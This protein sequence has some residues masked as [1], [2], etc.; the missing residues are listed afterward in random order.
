MALVLVFTTLALAF[1]HPHP[2]ASPNGVDIDD[3]EKPMHTT[4]L[5][6]GAAWELSQRAATRTQP[7]ASAQTKSRVPSGQYEL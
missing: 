6:A 1:A 7:P 4:A 3:L 5:M 2:Q